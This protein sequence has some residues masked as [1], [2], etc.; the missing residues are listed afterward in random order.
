MSFGFESDNG[1]L[2][3][4]VEGTEN[5]YADCRVR[6]SWYEQGHSAV[7]ASD[8]FPGDWYLEEDAPSSLLDTQRRFLSE[9][10]EQVANFIF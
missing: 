3:F 1:V 4:F 9:I 10:Q 6:N 2:L 8:H 7:G 5:L